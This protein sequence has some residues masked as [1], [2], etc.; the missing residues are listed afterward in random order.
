MFNEIIFCQT[1]KIHEIISHYIEKRVCGI[2]L[3]K[4]NTSLDK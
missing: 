2:K 4:T 3:H 1:D